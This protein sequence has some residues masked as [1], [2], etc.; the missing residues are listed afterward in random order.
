MQYLIIATKAGNPR[1]GT[2]IHLKNDVTNKTWCNLE[3]GLRNKKLIEVDEFPENRQVCGICDHQFK[4]AI[5]GAGVKKQKLPKGGSVNRD[6]ERS[7]YTSWDW[8]TARYKTLVKY[9]AKCMLCGSEKSICVDH[10][11]PRA[12]YPELEL[13]LDNLQVLC[14]ECNMGKG[15]WDETD[16]R[17]QVSSIHVKPPDPY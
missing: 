2:K 13:D 8:K 1:Q 9:G 12:K 4:K 11:K 10:I 7:F 17:P 5:R 6:Y 14:S 16:H 15:R 3:H